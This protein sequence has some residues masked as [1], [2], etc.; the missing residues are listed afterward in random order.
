M[1]FKKYTFLFQ[2][3][4][5][6]VTVSF[7]ISFVEWHRLKNLD[8]ILWPAL[9]AGIFLSILVLLFMSIRWRLLLTYRISQ[10]IPFKQV[11]KGY[12]LGS[13]FSILMP[14]SIGGD[15]M[16]IK[17]MSDKAGINLKQSGAIVLIERIF[18]VSALGVIFMIGIFYSLD[19]FLKNFNANNWLVLAIVLLPIVIYVKYRI[20]IYISLNYYRYI[21]ILFIS[22]AAH[23]SDILLVYIFM[24]ILGQDIGF[25]P[26]LLIMPLVYFATIIPISLGGLGVREGAMSGLLILFSVEPSI[27]KLVAFMLYLSKLFTAFFGIK[28]ASLFTKNNTNT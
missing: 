2:C 7:L 5:S 4:V 26:L 19:I 9:F 22:S 15:F 16:R 18:G 11:F 8:F 14:S 20:S 25:L 24:S 10:K 21:L 27:S 17:Y 1:K 13:F 6:I 3:L 23:F 28:D 12:L